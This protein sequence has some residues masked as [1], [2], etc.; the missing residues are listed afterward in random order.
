MQMLRKSVYIVFLCQLIAAA[1]FDHDRLCH[2]T[3][4]THRLQLLQ[5]VLDK[6]EDSFTITSGVA[7]VRPSGC[8]PTDPDVPDDCRNFN[9]P[10]IAYGAVLLPT[11][12]PNHPNCRDHPE[13]PSSNP[14][15]YQPDQDDALLTFGCVS[16]PTP[17][18]SL[19]TYLYER[20]KASIPG[21]PDVCDDGIGQ[22]PPPPTDPATRVVVDTPWY[23][24]YNQLNINAGNLADHH[25]AKFGSIFAHV[26]TANRKVSLDITQ[27]LVE[28]GFPP[29]AITID[30][31]PDG[32]V[33]EGAPSVRDTFRTIFRVVVPDDS[34]LIMMD[35]Y[36]NPA[37]RNLLAKYLTP[38]VSVPPDP[39]PMP[40]PTNRIT[41][42]SESDIVG[43]NTLRDLLQAVSNHY[44]PPNYVV[45]SVK[46]VF[47]SSKCINDGCYCWGDNYDTAYIDFSG[48]IYLS[49]QE[50]NGFAVVCGAN[51]VE[52]EYATYTSFGVFRLDGLA[53]GYI[54]DATKLSSARCY[55]PNL[56]H[57]SKFYCAEIR[58]K[59]SVTS[60]CIEP[61][62][63]INVILMQARI[64]LNP[65]TKTGPYIDE[66]IMPVVFGYYNNNIGQPNCYGGLHHA[67]TEL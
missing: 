62:I 53:V 60:P 64:N 54:D 1:A 24:T 20:G 65:S 16:P 30:S 23:D 61:V 52:L 58:S 43:D 49:D 47:N 51:H 19:R 10:A 67:K 55:A 18:F 40:T 50:P 9:N 25:N 27:A 29:S 66:L 42:T 34:S 59:C 31:I 63:D 6:L 37:N 32:M 36:M 45:H 13:T 8:D 48:P 39:F 33:L 46:K 7:I 35:A 11:C 17:Y 12:P 3:D 38:K 44:G 28:S 4:P 57:V 26:T 41:G 56:P 2:L 15:L 14:S 5:D 22:R 21:D